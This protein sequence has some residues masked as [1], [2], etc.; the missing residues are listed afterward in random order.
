MHSKTPES[1]VDDRGLSIPLHVAEKGPEKYG[2]F[3]LSAHYDFSFV[4][5]HGVFLIPAHM[6]LG[7][8]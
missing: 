1:L 5:Q 6:E 2:P 4:C 8:S 3:S 7:E